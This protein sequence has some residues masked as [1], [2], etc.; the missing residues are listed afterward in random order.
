MQLSLNAVVAA[1]LLLAAYLA[2]SLAQHRWLGRSRFLRG[3][4]PFLNLAVLYLCF[5]LFLHWGGVGLGPAAQLWSVSAGVLLACVLAIRVFEYLAFDLAF[6]R[7]LHLPMLLRDIVRWLVVLTVGYL[8]LHFNLGI[9][10][11]PL[12]AT[13][14]ALT[15]VL[16]IAMQDVLG[17]L[18]AGI[19]LNLEKPFALGDWVRIKGQT[20]AVENMTWRATRIRTFTDDH[21]VIPNAE[22]ARNEI[23]NYSHPTTTH[24]RELEVGVAYDAPPTLV[25][26]TVLEACAEVPGI[27]AGPG[28]VIWL[29]NYGD[30]AVTYRVKFW[31]NDYSRVFDIEDELMTSLWYRF[32]RAGIQIPFP[33]REV[34]MRTVTRADELAERAGR[35]R[36]ALD[37]L[38]AVPLLA[39]LPAAELRGLAR[40]LEARTYRRGERL[41]AQGEPGDS[42]FIIDGGSVEVLVADARGRQTRVAELGPGSFFGEM[43]LLT[44]EKRTATV[45]A[46]EDVSVL[47]VGK[48]DLG[49]IL[50]RRPRTV[51]A[52]SKVIEQRQRENLEKMAASRSLSEEERRAASSA[53]IIKRIRGF[54]GLRAS[55]NR[56]KDESGGDGMTRAISLALVLLAACGTAMAGGGLRPFDP[57]EPFACL[58][59]SPDGRMLA[60][61]RQDGAAIILCDPATGQS[62]L[63]EAGPASGNRVSWSPDGRLI[64]YKTADGRTQKA[65]VR[66]VVSGEAREV[67][68]GPLVGQPVWLG[69]SAMAVTAGSRVEIVTKGG[70]RSWDIGGYVNQ[71]AA[72][73]TKG[74]LAY[75]RETELM[76]L[77]PESGAREVLH[78]HECDLFDPA[79][80]PDGRMIS[81][82]S[83]DGR[84][85]VMELAGRA[86][87]D[88]GPGKYP[89][90][91]GPDSLL[92]TRKRHQAMSLAGSELAVHC[93]SS[94]RE[95]TM[96]LPGISL[97][98]MAAAGGGRLA[99][100]S[101]NDGTLYAG[102][103]GPGGIGVGSLSAFDLGG[104]DG[105]RW[106]APAH[107][108]R[109]KGLVDG[110]MPYIHQVYDTPDSFNGSAACGPTSCL[111]AI[112]YYHRYA[113]WNETVHVAAN[114]PGTHVSPHGNY[115]SKIYTYGGYV[116]DDTCSP[117]TGPPAH[118]AYGYC[119]THGAGAWA[120]KCRDYIR[121]HGLDSEYDLSV[122]W[123]DVASQVDDGYPVVLSTAITSAGHLM[124]VRGYVDGQHTIVV[125]DPAGNRNNGSY[126]NYPGDMAW[127][128]WPGY[129]NGYVNINSASWLVTAR[130]RHTRL[131]FASYPDTVD[132][133]HYYT[134][135][136]T[137]TTSAL[138]TNNAFQV[139]VCDGATGAGVFSA[140]RTG[141]DD[142]LGGIWNVFNLTAPR[143]SSAVYFRSCL[144][145]SGGSYDTRYISCWTDAHPTAVRPVTVRG[146]MENPDF[147]SGLLPWADTE[148]ATLAWD[149]VSHSGS[150]GLAIHPR[151]MTDYVPAVA[152]QDV[153]VAPGHSYL[154]SGWAR[155]NDGCGNSVRLAFMWYAEA[156]TQIGS[157]V[158]SPWLSADDPQF[159][160]LSTPAA[161]AP[162]GAAYACLRLYVKA[163][164][165]APDHF[166]DLYFGDPSGVAGG[167]GG[168]SLPAPGFR[169]GA[170]APSPFRMK[171]VIGFSL[172]AEGPARLAVYDACGRRL[173]A[174]VDG[175]LAAGAHHAAWDGRDGRGARAPAGVYF[176]H[177]EAGGKRANARAVLIR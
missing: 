1:A 93:A 88:L 57:D 64:G 94:G 43:S 102:T 22:I 104:R 152:H 5:R 151:V 84:V 135:T 162:A 107:A 77:D 67:A 100:A 31:I 91:L 92:F 148:N 69:R 150:R 176:I 68:S 171:T 60:A 50:A 61:G 73:V 165:T 146:Q 161:V 173:M 78:R 15:F 97:P 12:L 147:E 101:L 142:S 155:K 170:C 172:P 44:G 8:V 13:S 40:R 45:R 71:L 106:P 42:F 16:G 56:G 127:Y 30:F 167:N 7:S 23:V 37:R 158:V 145:P 28:P 105:P 99:V 96:G 129:N 11:T 80:S 168:P 21:V 110:W 6:A 164:G 177:L 27:L 143:T 138:Q 85:H 4:G 126:W 3:I 81:F 113:V 103:L 59:F 48:E 109:A 49:P 89:C 65:W 86:V 132:A 156:D 124:C 153:E 36:R 74:K 134:I 63:L 18:F 139:D 62:E 163:Y 32:R 166:D 98:G 20:G 175:V 131:A 95:G 174:L 70:R 55:G 122:T 116:F 75:C 119:C 54:F 169:L 72:D 76:S 125:N 17:N 118:G 140:A 47:V 159:Q 120:Y 26:R 144:T 87:R 33:I 10:L 160:P 53:G 123:S 38:G 149:T 115:D 108:G 34:T 83:L 35:E 157:Q 14:A 133:G 19:A 112:G 66:E 154:F 46:L 111:M 51:E 41:V 52:L 137:D 130:G 90:W 58:S 24:A 2:F 82:C 117:P 25:K 121:K 114:P 79:F 136:F 39:P 141:L 128:D 29:V 9:N